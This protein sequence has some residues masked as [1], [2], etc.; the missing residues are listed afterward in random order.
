[1][2]LMMSHAESAATSNHAAR[3][4]LAKTATQSSDNMRDEFIWRCYYRVLVATATLADRNQR[5]RRCHTDDNIGLTQANVK[6][7]IANGWNLF[8]DA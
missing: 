8:I 4:A 3:L 1:M 6:T 2:L 7:E 5:E